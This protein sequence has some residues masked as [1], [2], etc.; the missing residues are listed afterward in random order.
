MWVWVGE[1]CRPWSAIPA[2]MSIQAARGRAGSA[3]GVVVRNRCAGGEG[4]MEE[5]EEGE[6]E[7][8]RRAK[9]GRMARRTVRQKRSGCF[10]GWR[11]VTGIHH[12]LVWTDLTAPAGWA[13]FTVFTA[14]LL[15][16]IIGISAGVPCTWFPHPPTREPSGNKAPHTKLLGAMELLGDRMVVQTPFC[17]R[18]ENPMRQ[19]ARKALRTI[20]RWVGLYN[21]RGLAHHCHARG[22]RLFFSPGVATGGWSIPRRTR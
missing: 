12:P 18:L 10:G 16:I 8:E 13:P 6:E 21:T 7:A 20:P 17:A 3:R 15:I 19:N 14:A 22:K 4:R 11:G 9:G 1:W 2:E 5:E